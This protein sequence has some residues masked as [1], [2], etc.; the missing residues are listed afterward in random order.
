[1]ELQPEGEGEELTPEQEAAAAAAAKADA[2]E[3]GE[4]PDDL[5]DNI[6]KKS[7]ASLKQMADNE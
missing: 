2:L 6:D 3:K 7:N 4:S 5:E 1:M